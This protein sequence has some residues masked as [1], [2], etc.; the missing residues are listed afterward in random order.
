MIRSFVCIERGQHSSVNRAPDS[1]S[2]GH[3]FRIR[4]KLRENFLLQT[5]LSLLLFD[6]RSVPVL[7]QWHVKDTGHSAKSA[8]GRIRLNMHTPLTQRSRSVLTIYV[9]T[10]QGNELKRNSSE[11]AHSSLHSSMSHCGLI[12][13]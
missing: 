6:V 3:S 8:S 10:Y 9:K 7:P 4:Q 5:Q 12:L 13:A 11:N 2:E 1:C